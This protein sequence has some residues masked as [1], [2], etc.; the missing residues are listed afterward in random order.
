[1]HNGVGSEGSALARASVLTLL[2]GRA[3]PRGSSGF[4]DEIAL[5]VRRVRVQC[6]LHFPRSAVPNPYSNV[7]LV[8]CCWIIADVH[9]RPSNTIY[10]LLN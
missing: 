7:E 3:L 4:R 6:P 10:P 9:M 1:M 8:L 2:E 5:S